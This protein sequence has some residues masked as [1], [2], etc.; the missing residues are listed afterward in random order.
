MGLHPELSA[1]LDLVDSGRQSGE[2]QP[3]HRL[4]PDA[5][6]R[7]FSASS[8]LFDAPGDAGVCAEQ[9]SIP[10]RDRSAIDARLYVPDRLAANRCKPLLLFLH[11][12]GYVVG[13]L[14]THD[15]L[16][17]SL[18]AEAPCAVL[19]LGYRLAPEHKFPTALEDAIDA[20]RFLAAAASR[21]GIDPQRVAIGGDSAGGTLA[22]VLALLAARDAALLGLVPVLQL[23]F[24]P[25]TDAAAVSASMELFE[26]GYLLE[27]ETLRWF[28]TLYART[29]E[30]L[31]DWRMSPLRAADVAGAAPALVVLAEFDPLL[32]EGFA[33]ARKLEAAGVAVG[34]RTYSGMTHDFLRMASLIP[35]AKKAQA[36]IARALASAFGMEERP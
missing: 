34:L 18:A 14:D 36:E 3:L 29:P 5:A 25:V 22:A 31:A 27:A 21:L 26:E 20:L 17:R 13:S 1:F 30:D 9:I 23:L 33:Y 24:Y 6:R 10:T 15:G 28:H 32:D 8:R 7:E 11:G 16:C 2:T 4:T 19:S 12:G 35:E